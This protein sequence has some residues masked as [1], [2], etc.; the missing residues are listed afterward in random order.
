M[1]K[2][3]MGVFLVLFFGSGAWGYDIDV[4]NECSVA[5]KPNVLFLVDT[6]LSMRAQDVTSDKIEN[7]R[8]EGAFI[9]GRDASGGLIRKDAAG[10]DVT[11]NEDGSLPDGVNWHWDIS[12]DIHNNDPDVDCSGMAGDD[13]I[14]CENL[15]KS[16]LDREYSQDPS[17]FYSMCQDFENVIFKFGEF[18]GVKYWARVKSDGELLRIGNID[19]EDAVECLLRFGYF[20]GDIS[21]DGILDKNSNKRDLYAVGD[22]LNYQIY[23]EE[24]QNAI[25]WGQYN[26]DYDPSVDYSRY[27]NT[28]SSESPLG[29]GE[30]ITDKI[31]VRM[32]GDIRPFNGLMNFTSSEPGMYISDN[33]SG[34]AVPSCE[35]ALNGEDGA[36]EKGALRTKGWA[37][38][39]LLEFW[40]CICGGAITYTLMTG[41]FL[42]YLDMKKS[43]RYNAIDAMWDVIRTR[44]DDARF[45]IMQFDLG[46]QSEFFSLS[47][48][49]SQG[50]DL[51]AP[52]GSSTSDIKKILYG[53]YDSRKGR[54]NRDQ[55]GN[56][57]YF[58]HPSDISKETPLAESLIE[59]GCYFAGGESWFNSKPLDGDFFDDTHLG[60]G[61]SSTCTYKSPI[62]CSDQKNHVII[63][64]DGSPKDDFEIFDG[65]LTRN[66]KGATWMYIKE[67]PFVC[68]DPVSN[69]KL[70]DTTIGN[71]YKSDPLSS[72]NDAWMLKIKK[73]DEGEY[74]ASDGV[75]YKQ[76]WL[77]D[78]AKFL[79]DY[80]MSEL[81]NAK[82]HQNIHTHVIGFEVDAE[83]SNIDRPLMTLTAENGHGSYVFSSDKE[84]L[85]EGIIAIIES[86]MTDF[87]FS[88]ASSPV[89]QADMVYSGSDLYMSS[90]VYESGA[91]GRGNIKKYQRDEDEVIGSSD[92][93]LF[94]SNGKV[95]TSVR[96]CWYLGGDP[97]NNS[98]SDPK[99]KDGLARI[100][101]D[102]IQALSLTN[103]PSS[104]DVLDSVKS[105]RDILFPSKV[106]TTWSTEDAGTFFTDGSA[107]IPR[108]DNTSYTGD[109]LNTFLYKKIYGYGYNWP[110][111]DIIHSNLVL[112]RYPDLVGHVQ[113]GTEFLFVGTNGGMLHCFNVSGGTHAVEEEWAMI[114][115]DFWPR[116][117]ELESFFNVDE[118]WFADGLMTVYHV[119][120]DQAV[121]SNAGGSTYYPKI[122]KY[123]IAGERRGGKRYHIIDIST[124]ASPSY[125]ASVGG[126]YRAS[127]KDGTEEL[128][129]NGSDDLP[130]GQSWSRPQLCQVKNLSS[131]TTQGFLVAGGYDT[132]QDNDYVS[133]P[134]D[135][136]RF[137][138]IYDFNGGLIQKFGIGADGDANFI[139][140]C[141]VDARI[142]DPNHEEGSNR[143]F[144]RLHAG[145]LKGNVYRWE[146]IDMNGSWFPHKL[147][148]GSIPNEDSA[149]PFSVTIDG[150]PR[151]L[152]QKIFYAPVAGKAC[153]ED[154]VFWGTGDREHPLGDISDSSNKDYSGFV[155]SVY[156]V[157]DGHVKT[158]TRRD[159]NHFVLDPDSITEVD[160]NG[161]P[162]SDGGS[163]VGGVVQ[164]IYGN[165]TNSGVADMESCQ[166]DC[167]NAYGSCV[168]T[169]ERLSQYPLQ[170]EEACKAKCVQKIGACKQ[171]C[172]RGW[173]FDFFRRGEKVISAPIVLDDLLIFGTYTPPTLTITADVCA[174]GSDCVPGKGRIYVVSSCERAFA[175][176]SFRLVNNPMPQPSLIFDA[177]TGE[178]LISTGDGTII[179]PRLPVVVPEYWKHSGMDLLLES[180]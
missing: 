37:K 81:S 87:S 34:R 24:K 115:P 8:S 171:R 168:E 157:P 29:Y 69:K 105:T 72:D 66:G 169:C 60:E 118:H 75:N 132:N 85:K 172:G 36:P 116:L 52:C 156:C 133:T 90:F 176:R 71:Y 141:I 109:E 15:K 18:L 106:G 97:A 33:G 67:K 111:A 134:D 144:S 159:L 84:K 39:K 100:L 167:E 49:Q 120:S 101:Y 57:L 23:V 44:S 110:L 47:H 122:P 22:Y 139:E 148:S 74:V 62:Q 48:W 5:I 20:E 1:K 178:V 12:I 128:E 25:D 99:A 174:A 6:S 164:E 130:W 166:E 31:Y 14:A 165:I 143:I 145:D 27:H 126:A 117:H 94:D 91:R 124:I 50:A 55:F 129:E 177:D 9:I 175:V 98:K 107:T 83:V 104:K 142:H 173:F 70:T 125:E 108:E 26:S 17:T 150:T 155:D 30:Y 73:N 123:L 103:N 112:V 40:H 68:Y 163:F 45:G 51:S 4:F 28:S 140:A 61:S 160:K 41:N 54:M 180:P 56:P 3:T 78:V 80:D 127:F 179:N 170:D 131:Q 161:K 46:I 79:Y 42:N 64:T 93:K 89:S 162:V 136:G 16:Y 146:D 59:A 158:F 53:K 35:K 149:P 7:F 21:D 137:V 121:T 96:D 2:I 151:E 95:D 82:G 88:T 11:L 86:I 138:A 119:P 102:Q 154:R 13:L 43:R 58:G 10:N 38:T 113:S 135:E 152:F 114:Y 65:F 147:F 92:K 32:A 77:D 63:L 19:D 153:D 76:Q